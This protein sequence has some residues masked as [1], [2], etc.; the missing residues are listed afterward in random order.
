LNALL[1]CVVLGADIAAGPHGVTDA[2]VIFDRV[3]AVVDE[4]PILLSDVEHRAEPEVAR[5]L[6]QNV[7]TPEFARRRDDMLRAALQVLIDEQLL[8]EQL[9]DANAEVTDDQLDQAIEDVKRENNIPDDATFERA[10]R[11]EGLNL[12]S[13]RAQLKH[14][15]E[16]RKLLNAKVHSQAKVSDDD[17]Q[18]AYEREYVQAGGEEEVR[19]RHILI[20]VK[21]DAPPAEDAAAH[22]K[23]IDIVQRLR[24]GADFAQLAKQLSDGPSASQGGDL[25]FFKRGVMVTE[26]ENVAYALPKGGISDPVRTQFGWHVI[27]VLDRRKAPPPPLATVKEQLRQKLQKQQIERLTADYLAG[28]RKDAAIDIKIESLKPRP[29]TASAP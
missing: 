12:A 18:A 19:A 20:S 1:L 29:T 28:L 5:M 4:T 14:E 17:L 10:L 9:R 3:A 13:Y 26:F 8:Q 7:E 16:K 2:G 6:S 27:Q 23:A 15:L 21:R 22:Q 24:A 25:G 11:Q